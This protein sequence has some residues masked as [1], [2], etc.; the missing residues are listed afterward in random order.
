[1]RKI[2]INFDNL[3]LG[4]LF[5]YLFLILVSSLLIIVG[6]I[7]L[8]LTEHIKEEISYNLITKDP[9]YWSKE[10]ILELDTAQ[11]LDTEKKKDITITRNIIY[12]RL[13]K[14]GLEEVS[15]YKE[16]LNEKDILRVIVKTSK[17]EMLVDNLIQNRFF[18]KV[19]TK[20]EDVDFEDEENQ[21]AYLMGENYNP[22]EFTG[23]SFRNILLTELKDGSGEYSYFAVFK[24]WLTNEKTFQDFLKDHEEETIGLEIDGF[25]TPYYVP[26]SN[27]KTFAITVSGG[28]SQAQML[29]LLYNSGEI[30]LPFT[31][32]ETTNIEIETSTLDYIKLSIALLIGILLLYLILLFLLKED[33]QLTS[34]SLFATLLTIALW[35]SYLKLSS[36]PVDTWLLAIECILAVML[37]YILIHNKESQTAI[38]TSLVL[39][40]FILIILGIGYIRIF[41]REMLL[42][43]ILCQFSI[44]FTNWYLTNMKKTLAK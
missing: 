27:P 24:L 25:V 41:G 44:V 2:K 43:L 37:I 8:P 39:S 12:R 5:S 33:P 31:T 35:I 9:L 10:Y 4:S 34:T 1:M 42:V 38:T 13:N 32:I 22:T 28:E 30:P 18:I 23:S 14:A 3:Q 26:T 29:N 20:K 11:T 16:I 40:F 7:S 21:Y 17:D 6:L 19:V 36:T 15:I